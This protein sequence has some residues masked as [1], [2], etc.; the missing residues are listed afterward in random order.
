MRSA[1]PRV[2][3]PG[4]FDSPPRDVPYALR[5]REP[6]MGRA[7]AQEDMAAIRCGA[8]VAQIGGERFA[9]VGRQRHDRPA[10]ALAFDQELARPPVDI[11]EG[12]GRDLLRSKT[13]PREH[14][15]RGIVALA[16]SRRA[17]AALQYLL[18][19]LRRQ[20]GRQTRQA[21]PADRW[22]A[23]RQVRVGEA[24][25]EDIAQERSKA[26]AE[27]LRG[28]RASVTGMLFDI[29]DDI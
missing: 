25:G 1:A 18:D 23:G 16:D 5:G 21:I 3:D 26:G 20:I 28:R 8:P 15:Q 11:V 9:D 7:S 2:P 17:V 10:A 13:E 12:E 22:N 6:D 27:S 14:H 24:F 29:T 19:L 4:A